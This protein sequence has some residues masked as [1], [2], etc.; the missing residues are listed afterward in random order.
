MMSPNARFLK[1]SMPTGSHALTCAPSSSMMGIL[2]R[3]GASRRSSVPGLNVR[4]KTAIVSPSKLSKYLRAILI[5]LSFW[6]S[7]TSMAALMVLIS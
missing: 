2:T 3:E 7:L 1:F 4:P 6:F 5:G